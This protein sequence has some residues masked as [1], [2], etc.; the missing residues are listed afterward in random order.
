MESFLTF[1]KR[2]VL[3]LLLAATF[4]AGATAGEEDDIDLRQGFAHVARKAIPAVVFV[5]V[6]KEVR[7]GTVTPFFW[8]WP[9]EFFGDDFLK[10]FF[11]DRF[12]PPRQPGP[13]Q[14]FIQMGQ[15]SGFIISRD[16]YILTNTHVVNGADKITVR[17][18]GGKEY[19]AR[20]IG[21]D[22]RTEI[23]VIK[24]DADDLPVLEM[25]EAAKLQIGEW[26]VAIGNPF[27]FSATLTVGVVSALGR[28]NMGIADYEDFIQ[29]DAAINPGNSGGPLLDIRGRVVGI[30]T[31]I[32]SRSGGYMGI[33]F[34]VPIDMAMAIKDQLIS[35]GK[36]TRGYLGIT[37]N[38]GEVTDEIARS[39]GLDS[40]GGVLIADVVEGS[41]ADKAGLK[42]GDIIREMN[43]QKVTDSTAFRSAIASMKPGTVVELKVWR[44]G[45]MVKVKATLDALPD[46]T[47]QA[48]G[49]GAAAELL[50]KAIGLTV[51]EAS[52]EE[53]RQRGF[54]G[55]SGPGVIITAVRPGSPAFRERLQ[56]GEIIVA[57]NQH[58]I[59]T[60]ADLH[61]AIVAAKDKG[62]KII[63][64][65]IRA[66]NGTRY[67]FVRP[68]WE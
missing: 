22:P 41:A 15:G 60:V 6:E 16:G 43:G 30:N 9:E 53:L 49:P 1:A 4:H 26:V 64:L 52:A 63:R 2:M 19:R 14:S 24:I 21:A 67:A 23:A 31:A 7:V 42:S 68:E 34:A 40:G 39:F 29:T 55:Q 59:T 12:F 50:E 66:P 54:A 17:L 8:S 65:R 10:R 36:V 38:P 58:Q 44:E 11:G 61:A 51:A 32:Y 13:G 47:P 33:G 27:G 3:A 45:K 35:E 46:K 20:H 18:N 56:P 62:E 57:V 37:I 5:Q 25:G 48:V 28:R